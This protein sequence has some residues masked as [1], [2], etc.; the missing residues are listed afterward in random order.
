MKSTT[1]TCAVMAVLVAGQL[2]AVAQEPVVGPVGKEGGRMGLRPPRDGM[3][4][5]GGDVAMEQGMLGRFLMNPKAAEDLGLT[6]EQVKT[7]KEQ[8]EPLRT[9]MESLRKE[10]E[11]ASMEQ[12]KLLTGDSVEEDALMAAVE[13]TGAARLK[14]AKLAMRQ[15]LVV[16][17]TLTPE[18]VAK[19][20]EM[21]RERLS[22][23]PSEGGEG[24]R[25]G[26]FFRR[27]MKDREGD[28]PPRERPEHP[29]RQKDAPPAG[30]GI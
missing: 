6:P 25:K 22:R 30:P 24:G 10:L 18:Q 19:A 20:R 14:M 11:Q 9:E 29:P 1:G 2:I 8:S 26:E 23:R 27:R 7:L 12:A 5:M 16:K 17:R 13:K 3:P 21:V 28:A 15:L 4:G